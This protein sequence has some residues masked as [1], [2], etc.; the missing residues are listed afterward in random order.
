[1]KDRPIMGEQCPRRSAQFSRICALSET[2]TP[3][4]LSGNTGTYFRETVTP[5]PISR[6]TPAPIFLFSYF[7]TPAPI[8]ILQRG[9]F[10]QPT[11]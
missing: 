4:P 5:A 11:P 9:I 2:V 1:M 7:V 8:S 10:W 6:V 3:A